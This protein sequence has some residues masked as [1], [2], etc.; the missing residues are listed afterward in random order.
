MAEIKSPAAGRHA[1]WLELFFDLV[2]VAAIVQLAH[3]VH[4]HVTPRSV[5]VFL[6]LYLAVWI[7]WLSFPLYANGGGERTRRRAVV[8]GMLG[9]AVMAA[10][11]PEATGE[12]ARVFAA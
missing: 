10:A 6:G 5:A 3:R 8:L 4:D 9:I 12:R 11:V 7:A 2:V 1:S